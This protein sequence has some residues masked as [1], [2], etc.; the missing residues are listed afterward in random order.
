MIPSPTS[1]YRDGFGTLSNKNKS[2]YGIETRAVVSGRAGKEHHGV[3]NTP[4]Y[5]ASTIL[6]PDARA[7]E[8]RHDI[9]DRYKVVYGLLG[10]PTTFSLETAMLDLTGGYDAVL[11]SSG[12]SAC[13][14]GLASFLGAGDHLLITDSVYW[15]TR[16]FCDQTLTRFGV[17]VTYYDPEIGNDIESLIKPNTRVIYLESPGS[18]TFEVQDIPTITEVAKRHGIRTLL[19][20]TWATPLHF[21]AFGHGVDVVIHAATKY[22]A[23]HSDVLL[24]IIVSNEAAWEAVRETK[25]RFGEGIGPEEAYLTTRGLKTLPTRLRRHHEQGLTLAHWLEQRS[26]TSRILHPGLPGAPGHEIFKR[27]FSG[28]CGLFGVVLRDY[29]TEAVRDMLNSLELFGIGASW[30]GYESLLI[31][32][33]PNR[34]RTA[35]EWKATGPLLRLHVG[36]ES[37]DD[38]IADLEHG[39]EQLARSQG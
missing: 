20:A 12:L 28:A 5:R 1:S 6:H 14:I 18:L 8:T 21:D 2:S 7:F 13:T 36:L 37:L 30:G 16:A 33:F 22:L 34:Y 11:T 25:V 31:P 32:A 9:F 23:G 17:E 27:D 4:V 3:L 24:G 29:T 39:F 10:T 26:E 38:L 15:P 35:K 19:D